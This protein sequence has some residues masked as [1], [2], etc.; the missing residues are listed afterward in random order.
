ML[1]IL[2]SPTSM[3]LPNISISLLGIVGLYYLKQSTLLSLGNS[4]DPVLYVQLML[5]LYIQV[6]VQYMPVKYRLDH[7]FYF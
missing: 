5:S 7:A 4:H 6:D 1:V 2:S 3:F